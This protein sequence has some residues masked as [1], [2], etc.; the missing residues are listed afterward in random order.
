MWRSSPLARERRYREGS[1]RRRR[2]P[3]ARDR[4]RAGAL[5][6]RGRA[7]AARPATRGSRPTPALI[8]GGDVAADRRG[9][10]SARPCDLVV[11]GP[12]A[13]LVDGLVDALEAEGVARFR[14]ARS[15]RAWRARRS[16][17]RS[18]WPRPACRPRRTR[19]SATARR[20]SMRSRRASYPTVLKAD[21]LA[22]GKGV[23]ICA[24]E[25]EARAASRSVLRRAPL[26]RRPRSCW[27][28]S[29]TAPSSR[30]S[31]SA[32]GATWSPSLRR[33][34]TSG[35]STATAARTP[36]AWAATRRCR[37]RRRRRSPEIATPCTGRSSIC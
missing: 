15:R 6:G 33:R 26:R 4:A 9:R 29:S 28:S 30:C 7:A 1:R 21:G 18:S 36:A 24:S 22:A 2:R 34:T 25:D 10:P 17:P 14:P 37:V 8:E 35:S 11:V 31:R 27:R 12:E 13:P 19:C 16:T 3:R 32:T 20:R 23:I 5:A